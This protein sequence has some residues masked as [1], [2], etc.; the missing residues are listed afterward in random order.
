MDRNQNKGLSEESITTL[1]TPSNIVVPR[2]SYLNNAKVKLDG[3]CLKQDKVSSTYGNVVTFFVYKLHIWPSDLH[4]ESTLKYC[5]FGAVKVTKN[6][7]ADGYSYP[8]YC[9]RFDSQLLF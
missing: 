4:T 8:G 9:I 3:S 5:L 1:A 2:L 7:D 6:T